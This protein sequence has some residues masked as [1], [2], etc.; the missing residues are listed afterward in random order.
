MTA[1]A[2]HIRYVEEE[3]TNAEQRDDGEGKRDVPDATEDMRLEQ[4]SQRFPRLL[5][6]SLLVQF[7]SSTDKKRFVRY[8]RYLRAPAENQVERTLK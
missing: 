2:G 5:G 1:S 7:A 4:V 6:Y 8:L 3:V